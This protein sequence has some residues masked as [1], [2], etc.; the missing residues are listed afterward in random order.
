MKWTEKIISFASFHMF[1][2]HG[3]IILAGLSFKQPHKKAISFCK[4]LS[5]GKYEIF[6]YNSCRQRWNFFWRIVTKPGHFW[7][8]FGS[9]FCWQ[10]LNKKMKF[11]T[12]HCSK[13]KQLVNFSLKILVFFYHILQE[14]WWKNPGSFFPFTSW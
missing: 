14:V 3:N 5:L 8:V 7:L 2:C 1:P 11:S 10:Y 13:N 4:C 9:T 6:I 12:L